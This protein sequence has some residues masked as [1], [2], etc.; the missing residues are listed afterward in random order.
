MT[1]RDEILAA[2]E[3]L[4]NRTGRA[5]LP[6]VEIVQEVLRGGGDYKESTIRTH[7]TSSMCVDAP[8]NHATRY[9]DLRR[10]DRGLYRRA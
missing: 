6:L 4:E 2:M 9:P 5:G 10:V 3:R 8:P 7:V 1:C